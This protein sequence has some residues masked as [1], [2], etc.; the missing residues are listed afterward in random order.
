MHCSYC[1]QNCIFLY[2]LEAKNSFFCDE[3]LFKIFFYLG[4]YFA[5]NAAHLILEKLHSLG[6]VWL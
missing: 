1:T 3:K 2:F 6:M 5:Q 4:I